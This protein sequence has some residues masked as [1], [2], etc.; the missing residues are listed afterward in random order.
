MRHAVLARPLCSGWFNGRQPYS[1]SLPSNR[2]MPLRHRFGESLSASSIRTFG[3]CLR[4]QRVERGFSFCPSERYVM[5]IKDCCRLVLTSQPNSIRVL[6]YTAIKYECL[7]TM[8]NFPTPPLLLFFLAVRRTLA[9]RHL[10]QLGS[11]ILGAPRNSL[12]PD[13]CKEPG[14][15][16]GNGRPS[17]PLAP[18]I[19]VPPCTASRV[20]L[21]LLHHFWQQGPQHSLNRNMNI[22]SSPPSL[23]ARC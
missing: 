22:R 7:L 4:C 9:G 17:H 15:Q 16:Q 8:I 13:E 2:R 14:D 20:T 18:P 5:R 11:G 12:V 21:G 19:V 6:H 3:E 1:T 23:V 10:F